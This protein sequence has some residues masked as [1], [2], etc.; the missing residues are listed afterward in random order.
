M[1]D[2]EKVETLDDF[3]DSFYEKLDGGDFVTTPRIA[4]ED[5]GSFVRRVE[6][7]ELLEEA[8]RIE[9]ELK[10]LEG[11]ERKDELEWIEEDVENE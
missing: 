5:W 9:Q 11:K 10:S 2:S 4:D 3:S 6:E 7:Q 8:K 1:E